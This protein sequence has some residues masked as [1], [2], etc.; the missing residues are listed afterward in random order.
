MIARVSYNGR[1][2]APTD[3]WRNQSEITGDA[4]T[5]RAVATTEAS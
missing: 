2:W 5:Q 4:L 1:V 3:D